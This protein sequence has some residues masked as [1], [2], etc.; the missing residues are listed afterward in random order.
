[1]SWAPDASSSSSAAASSRRPR[2]ATV[3]S[4]G[5]GAAD[6]R[7]QQLSP[8]HPQY[9]RTYSDSTRNNPGNVRHNRSTG[10]LRNEQGLTSTAE[11]GTVESHEGVHG[12]DHAQEDGSSD[13]P[14]R[15]G[16]ALTWAKSIIPGVPSSPPSSGGKAARARAGTTNSSVHRARGV[17]GAS[18]LSNSGS[19][20]LSFPPPATQAEA[21]VPGN[22]EHQ[23]GS[24]ATRSRAGTTSRPPGGAYDNRV[25]DLLDVIDPEVQMLN[26][27]GDVQNSFFIPYTGWFDR[28]RKVQLTKPPCSD[29][30]QQAQGQEDGRDAP[31]AGEEAQPTN[32]RPSRMESVQNLFGMKRRA[33][34]SSQPETESAPTAPKENA[35]P[36]KQLPSPP[37]PPSE[38]TR[39]HSEADAEALGEAPP[40]ET[41]EDVL[42]EVEVVKGKYFV[43]PT[44]LVDMNDWT[45]Q[46]KA[47]LDDYVRHLLHSRKEKARRT[48][49]GFK[50]YVKTPLGAFVTVYASLLTIFGL[51]WVLLLI[52]WISTG[53]DARQEYIIEVIDQ[54]L[55]ALFCVTG[56]GFIPWRIMD[57]YHTYFIVKYHRKT[58]KLRKARGLPP[59]EDEND[60]PNDAALNRDLELA[61]RGEDAVLTDEEQALLLKHQE[62][63]H[64]SH[65]YYRPHETQTHHAF[66]MR[67]L[68][69]VIVL[70]DLHSTFQLA[71]GSA[72]WSI[73]YHRQWKSILTTIILCFSLTCN[74]SGGVC[75][76]IGNRMSRKK[77]VVEALMRQAIT[78]EAIRRKEDA[79]AWRAEKRLERQ[80]E[81][82]RE[83]ERATAFGPLRRHS[84]DDAAF[85][86]TNS[87]GAKLQKGLAR[88]GSDPGMVR[89]KSRRATE[90]KEKLFARVKGDQ[91]E[92]K[93]LRRSASEKN[94]VEKSGRPASDAASTSSSGR[95][96]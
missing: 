74:I 75:I 29:P 72:T 85:P 28:T 1:M 36:E 48:W 5:A 62:A 2:S 64:K 38:F 79:E 23:S 24:R 52:G 47:D 45:E 83:R 66:P 71:L 18:R 34:V 68:I 32:V 91:D 76:A 40:V 57:T 77:D 21:A 9:S 22:G 84:E 6:K 88:R 26:T 86:R 56:L 30:A 8:S 54:I 59:L 43:L 16:S 92:K 7:A 49:R 27:L 95:T 10:A 67:V 78:A 37:S 20:D 89:V 12:R 55:V 44:T 60:L 81:Q 3:A 14:T 58:L 73:S 25:Q 42:A 31:R 70:C 61:G 41:D 94:L 17:S 53:N 82:Q 15:T 19:I 51:V 4:P 80:R 65:T 11:E 50:K 63:L 93:E 35:D 33:T 46:E 96:R 13:Q 39:V 90:A 69:A 87:L